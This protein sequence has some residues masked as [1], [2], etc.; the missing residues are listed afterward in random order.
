MVTGGNREG[1]KQYKSL[2]SLLPVST[3]VLQP[4]G[5]SYYTSTVKHKNHMPRA[6]NLWDPLHMFNTEKLFPSRKKE[7]LLGFEIRQIE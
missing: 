3:L 7:G 6:M 4:L 5:S 2:E 1:E